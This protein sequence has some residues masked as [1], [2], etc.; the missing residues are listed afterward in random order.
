MVEDLAVDWIGGNLYWNDY[1]VETI[2]VAKLDGSMKTILFSE[3]ITNPRG[4]EVDPRSGYS[5]AFNKTFM[6]FCISVVLQTN[7][8]EKTLQGLLEAWILIVVKNPL[9]SLFLMVTVD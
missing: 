5:T 2:E 6:Q 4:I 8:C 7:Y 1:V 3:N 9:M